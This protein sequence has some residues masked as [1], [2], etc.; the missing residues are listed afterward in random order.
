[1]TFAPKNPNAQRWEIFTGSFEVPDEPFLPHVDASL[2]FDAFSDYRV[3][4]AQLSGKGLD[5]VRKLLAGE[6]VEQKASG[7]SPA[8]W[9]EL[10]AVLG[11]DAG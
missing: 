7:M 4:G 1:M 9:R 6:E 8:E 11:R 3:G 2:A 5:V 10:M